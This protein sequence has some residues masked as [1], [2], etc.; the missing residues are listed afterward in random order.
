ML[1]K[2]FWAV[3]ALLLIVG[4]A[5]AGAAGPVRDKHVEAELVSELSGLRPGSTQSIGILLRM[6]EHWHTYWQNPGDSGLPTE[7][8]W[9]LPAGF[10]AGPLQWPLPERSE[11]AGLASL[12]YE[13]QVLLVSELK[14][15]ATLKPG[16]KVKLAADVKWLMCEE[17][18]IPGK[19]RVDL[20]LPVAAD[21]APSAAAADFAATR[22]LL[23]TPVEGVHAE[24]RVTDAKVLLDLKL[25][26][27]VAVGDKLEFY[28]TEGAWL[29]LAADQAL[30]RAGDG[31]RLELQRA[32]DTE[33]PAKV[34]GILVCPGTWAIPLDL[35]LSTGGTAA[36]AAT[37]VR[38]SLGEVKSLPAA[39][40]FAFLGGMALNLMPCV[41][42]VLSLK[43]MSFL[44]HGSHG[45]GIRQ[46]LMF[47]LGVLVSFW[48]VVALLLGLRAAGQELGWGFQLQSP[49]FVA[50]VACLFFLMALNLLGVFEVGLGLTRLG[51]VAESGS[52]S[53]GS[54]LS[55]VLATIV[56]TPCTAPFM[57]SAIGFALTQPVWAIFLVFTSL[58]LGMAAPYVVLAAWPALLNRLPRPGAWMETFKQVLAFPL[59]LTVVY[60]AWV[61]DRQAGS[62]ALAAL[63]AGMVLLG[64]AS[65]MYGRWGM[66]DRFVP[67]ALAFVLFVL[68]LSV[69][70][71]GSGRLA[72]TPAAG[73][74]Q[75]GGIAWEP[76]SPQRQEA[77]LAE[78]RPVLLD[79][80]AA[81][82]LSCQVNERVALANPEV[83]KALRERGVATLKADWT[84]RD[85]TIT[86]A[87]ASFGRSGVPLYVLYSGKS[88]QAPRILPEVLTPGLVLEALQELPVTEQAKDAQARSAKRMG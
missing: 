1:R 45:R 46:A 55:G 51:D 28:P 11:L 21:P 30:T 16:D 63:L 18:C 3:L 33:A 54:F 66:S 86:K 31:Y 24:A 74:T 36:P 25:P 61:L 62:E 79:F 76:W 39:L 17:T 60:F 14:V 19:A 56:A 81:W 40:L 73:A 75:H 68:A 44:E 52:G 20:E 13:G 22:K 27:T 29:D 70:V 7:V 82:C 59:L 32:K 50:F 10:E 37:D 48:A 6:D 77:L 15:P 2:S 26:S 57:G 53:W 23:P 43:V 88:G 87:L 35:P 78:G 69:A 85:E 80:T 12:A 47:T 67:R 5:P 9:E 64:M 49:T 41:F 71:V 84:N 4:L 72:A 58:A 83:E 34:Q 8:K 42:P 65:W 38:S